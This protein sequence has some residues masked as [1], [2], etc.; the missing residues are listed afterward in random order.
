MKPA[1]AFE[2]ERRVA[3]V[4]LEELKL[5]VGELAGGLWQFSVT[6]P[7]TGRGV[8]IQIFWERPAR[9]SA[10]ASSAI[11]SSLPAFA[12]VSNCWSQAAASNAAN[13]SRKVAS[14]LGE[15]FRIS[16]SSFS[17]LVMRENINER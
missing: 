13:H 1:H 8:V 6:T 12:S 10:R 5:L 14:S 3:R 15:S 11:R 7:E 2:M 16:L 9:W 4:R 17:I